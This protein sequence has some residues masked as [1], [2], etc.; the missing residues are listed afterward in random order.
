MIRVGEAGGNVVDM[1]HRLADYMDAD[2]ELRG[3][4]RSALTY[5]VFTL[6]ITLVL[7]YFMLN[8][9]LPGFEPM[10]RDA[11][12]DMSHYPVTQVLLKLSNLTTSVWD[13][14]LLALVIG[15]I[16]YLFRA[17]LRTPEAARATDRFVYRLPAV[18]S[19]I[20]LTV[21]SRVSNTLSALISSGVTLAESLELTAATAGRITVEE[22]LMKVSMRVQEGKEFSSAVRETGVFPP[23]MLQMVALGERSGDL[24]ATLD[25]VARYYQGQLDNGIKSFSSLLQPASM[26]LIGGLVL[27][28]VIGV[29]LP[30]M[31]IASH[32]QV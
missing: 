13:E 18:G 7:F 24:P 20:E 23:L 1:I 32:I 15:A 10:W 22:A 8:F 5:P 31:G 27:L 14:I 16:F 29:F 28:F 30:I 6:V 4:I 25:R 2:L 19:F 17:V 21:M 11:N 26:L 12:L 9:I 3:K